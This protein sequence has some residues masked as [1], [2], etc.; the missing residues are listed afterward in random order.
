MSAKPSFHL[1]TYGCQMNKLD[2]ELVESRLVAAGH[3]R[4]ERE[5][6]AGIVLLN[7]CS[8]RE[9][10]E[11]RVWGRLGALKARKRLDPS[12]VIGVLG[13]MAQEHKLFLRTRMPHVDL[14]CGTMDFG[15]ID[16]LVD[17]VLATRQGVV[18]TGEDHGGD[19]IVRD[20]TLRPSRAQAFVNV[21]RGCNMPCT[22]CI[23]PQTRGPELSRPIPELVDE[24]GRLAADGV[25]EV[26]LLGQTVNAWGH[27]LPGK[28]SLARLL[29]ELH[30]IPALRRI[31]FITSHPNFLTREL[32]ETMAEL[33]RVSRYFH[34]PAQSGSDAVLQRMRRLYTREKYLA[35]IADLRALVPDI[36]FASDFIVGFPGET[37][38][39]HEASRSLIEEVGFAQSFVFRYSP[40]PG[41]VADDHLRDDVPLADKERRNRELLEVQDRIS[42]ARNRALVGSVVEVLVEGPSRKG[43]GRFTGRTARN[44]IV[45]YDGGRQDEVGRY[46]PVRVREARP[47]SLVGERLDEEETGGDDV[48]RRAGDLARA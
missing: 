3:P 10:A 29:R 34:L 18:A 17:R 39:D 28:P 5:E 13:C 16:A 20:V 12:L 26:T 30:A 45:H 4:A 36:E 1:V 6:D 42:L 37:E 9:H 38:A 48:G 25:T 27:D 23:V 35:R 31:S 11:D 33:P 8:V 40:R 19:G 41:T 2:S 15:A 22:F 47:H 7:T 46:L 24:V 43:E 32:M 44:R 21:I 14:V